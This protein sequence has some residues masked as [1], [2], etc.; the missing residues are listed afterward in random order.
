[1][2]YAI[3]R[4]S[5]RKAG[6]V[7]A[8]Y[9]HNERKKEAYKSNPDIDTERS[10]WNYHLVR[11]QQTYRKEVNC[12]IA[13][14]GCKVRSNSTVMVETLITASPEFMS[15]LPPPEQREYFSRAFDFMAEKI[16]KDN[17]I[18]AVVHMDERTPHMHL[19]FC[20]ITEDKKLSA[21]AI[22]GNQAQLSRWQ[23][24]YHKVMSA[25]W[26]ELERGVSSMVTKRKHIPVWLFKQAERL[27]KQLDGISTAL[28]DI[29]AFNAGKKRDKALSLLAAWLPEV[30]KFTAQIKT[31]DG[32]IRYL[33]ETVNLK[34]TTAEHWKDKAGETEER[35][36]RANAEI[37]KLRKQLGQQQ[38]LLERI[39][40]E[41]LEQLK[42]R[43]GRDR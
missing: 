1:M 7:T 43:K 24:E 21:K 38:R 23:T 17:I 11:P 4:F 27:D 29:N 26:P 8:N 37:F 5:K 20:P 9:T 32:E 28:A 3:L 41:V 31:V 16:G 35:I 25:R 12:L 14:A 10:N 2:P 33:K 42:N 22:L 19:S 36:Y 15:A 34:Q 39:P 40:P 6:G 18:S 13:A 30:E